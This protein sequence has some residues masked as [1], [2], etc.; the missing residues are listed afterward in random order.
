MDKRIE[1]VLRIME[2]H[3]HE[4]LTVGRLAA[5]AGL[6]RSRF[7]FIFTRET[8]KTFK[9][10]LLALR[11]M[12]AVELLA[13]DHLSIKEIASAAGYRHAPN[14]THDF[15]RRF[16]KAP[17]HYRHELIQ[18]RLCKTGRFTN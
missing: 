17:T 7:E 16:G 4:T 10:H 12:K 18:S 6:S 13:A 14:F 5:H 9:S 1:T 2:T 11:M 15:K 8:G 3:F